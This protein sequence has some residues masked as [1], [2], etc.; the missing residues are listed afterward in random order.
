[1]RWLVWLY[2]QHYSD[3]DKDGEGDVVHMFAGLVG[4]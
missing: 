2:L 3:D 4:E 1:M